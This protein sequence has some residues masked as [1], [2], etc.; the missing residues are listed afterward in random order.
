MCWIKLGLFETEFLHLFDHILNVPVS[1]LSLITARS[2]TR[3]HTCKLK[4]GDEA[5]GLGL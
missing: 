4:T 1:V 2:T 3:Q 5:P